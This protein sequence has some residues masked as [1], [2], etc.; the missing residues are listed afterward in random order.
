M[1]KLSA[2]KL[3]QIGADLRE[4]DKHDEAVIYLSLAIVYY[5]KNNNYEGLV[6]TLKD[7]TLVWKH[8]FLLTKDKT[9][10][11]LAK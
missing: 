4:K 7:R 10:A 3:H 8:Y 5:Q 6:D 1:L 2:K 9:Y 11:I